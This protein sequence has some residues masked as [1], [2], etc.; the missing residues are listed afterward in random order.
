MRPKTVPAE[1]SQFLPEEDLIDHFDQVL[2]A[3]KLEPLRSINDEYKRRVK[4]IKQKQF[5]SNFLQDNPGIQHKAGVTMGG[6]FILV[7]HD[8]PRSDSCGFDD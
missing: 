4:E 8:D 5:L 3:C 7:Y 2:F 6:T 1:L